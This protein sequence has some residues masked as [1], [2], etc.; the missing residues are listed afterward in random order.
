MNNILAQLEW[1]APTTNKQNYLG[2]SIIKT[3]LVR[4]LHNGQLSLT[5]EDFLQEKEVVLAIC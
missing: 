3:I 5:D 2:I 4:P 1:D